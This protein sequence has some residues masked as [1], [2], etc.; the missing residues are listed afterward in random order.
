[1]STNEPVKTLTDFGRRYLG[2]NL[3]QPYREKQVLSTSQK[4][5]IC[6]M[7][8][9]SLRLMSITYSTNETWHTFVGDVFKHYSEPAMFWY[10]ATLSFSG[11]ALLTL[12]LNAWFI[13]DDYKVKVINRY[14]EILRSNICSGSTKSD[15]YLEYNVKLIEK[16]AKLCA[17]FCK[18]VVYGMTIA[19]FFFDSFGTYQK[20]GFSKEFGF[21]LV[22]IIQL[23]C[24][25]S[26][27]S[28]ILVTS[29]SYVHLVCYIHGLKVKRFRNAM[30]DKSC[31]VLFREFDT[32][33]SE[34]KTFNSYVKYQFFYTVVLSVPL[35]CFCLYQ[36]I[37]A[38]M[39]I[40]M[41]TVMILVSIEFSI[42]V[43]LI[44]F[45]GSFVKTQVGTQLINLISS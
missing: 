42:F 5:K 21:S 1:M 10:I 36:A 38:D 28:G 19:A 41:Q 24:W 12:F 35:I 44:I 7:S 33:C 34:L 26:I 2:L 13:T 30:G 20:Y 27:G 6:F 32:I 40:W 18:I 14:L 37:L 9:Y 45:S 22:W 43:T 16:R 39:V 15:S 3:E 8:Y 31:A 11:I 23:V 17:R 29:Y 25:A 4:W